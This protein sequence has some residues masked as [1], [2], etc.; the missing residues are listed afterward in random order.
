M[1]TDFKTGMKKKT[2]RGCWGWLCN[3]GVCA[4]PLNCTLT[5]DKMVSFVLYIYFPTIKILN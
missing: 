2:W 3:V 4:L 1:G 5:A